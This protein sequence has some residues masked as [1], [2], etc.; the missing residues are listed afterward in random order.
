M[1]AIQINS[2]SPADD[3]L[4]GYLMHQHQAV[5]NIGAPGSPARVHKLKAAS[6]S[7]SLAALLVADL[8]TAPPDG[9]HLE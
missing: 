4:P 9:L 7:T 5:Y 8:R 1:V 3:C 2:A 6:H